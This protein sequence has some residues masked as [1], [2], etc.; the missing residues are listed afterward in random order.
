[1]VVEVKIVYTICPR[2]AFDG[3]RNSVE[4]TEYFSNKRN[5]ANIYLIDRRGR[6]VSRFSGKVNAEALRTPFREI[7]AAIAEAQPDD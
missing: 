5:V 2:D 3:L 7:D 1:M 6:V 4:W